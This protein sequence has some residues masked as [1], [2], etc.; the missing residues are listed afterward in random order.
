LVSGHD[1]AVDPEAVL[2]GVQ[3]NVLRAYGSAFV[4][5]RHLVLEV[6]DPEQARAA[7]RD[8]LDPRRPGPDLTSGA[9]WPV[10]DGPDLCTNIGFTA[11]GLGAIGVD[12]ADVDTFPPE[13]T[14]GMAARARLLGDVGPSAPEHWRGGLNQTH[15]VDVIITLHAKEA[16]LLDAATDTLVWRSGAWTLVGDP[17]DGRAL[18]RDVSDPSVVG[19]TRLAGPDDERAVHFGYRDGIEQPRIDEIQVGDGTG[20]ARQFTPLGALLVGERTTMPHVWWAVPQPDV[21]G[22]WGVF[23]AFRVLEQDVVAFSQLV[24]HTVA[25]RPDLTPDLVAA[26]FCGR[27]P[28]GDPLATVEVKV[29]VGHRADRTP[30]IE[31]H[32]TIGFADDPDGLRC[33]IGAHVRRANPRDAV[34]VQRASN[35]VRRVTRRGMPYGPPFRPGQVYDGQPRGLLGNF[36]CADLGAQFESLQNDWINLGFQDPRITG[37]NDPLVGNH[38]PLE[39]P[40]RFVPDPRAP[41]DVVEVPVPQLVRTVGGAYTFLPSMAAVAWLA[42]G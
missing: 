6:G 35:E 34:I 11:H 12:S 13:F 21:L 26:K 32:R 14:Q 30:I 39:A 1:R 22:R 29:L 20:D 42:R 31:T 23:N 41:D 18:A 3:G 4:H 36:L 38:D 15:R 9:T 5:V 2:A 40:F 33:P 16:E 27:Y 19:G 24:D 17:I 25:A 8:L 28:N 10:D 37:T 7:L